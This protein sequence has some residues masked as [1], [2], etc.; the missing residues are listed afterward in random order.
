MKRKSWLT[1]TTGRKVILSIVAP[2]LCA[3]LLSQIEFITIIE[4]FPNG[5]KSMWTTKHLYDFTQPR[6]LFGVLTLVY[7]WFLWGD[8]K[9]HDDHTA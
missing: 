1:L 8:S 6:V 5:T 4:R 2:A 7:L 3:Y 9:G